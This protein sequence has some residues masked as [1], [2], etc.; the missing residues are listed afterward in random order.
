MNKKLY[1]AVGVGIFI[2]VAGFV[3]ITAVRPHAESQKMRVVTSFYPLYFFASE[4]GGDKAEVMNVTPAGAEPHDYEPTSQ[5][6]IAIQDSDLFVFNGVGFE[7]WVGRILQDTAL[8]GTIVEAADGLATLEGDEHEHEHEED[9]HVEAVQGEDDHIMDPHV[10]L[11]PVL[12]SRMADRIAQGFVAADPA[13]ASYY[14]A[15]AESLKARLSELDAQ[16]QTGLARCA[17][18]DFVTSHA[19]F[20]YLAAAYKINQ[21]P[22]SG[23]SPKEEPSVRQLATIATFAREH[24]VQHIFFEEL[25][26]PKLAQTVATEIGAQTLVLNPIEGLAAEDLKAGKNYLTEMSENLA[27]LRIALQC[28]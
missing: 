9:E 5:D 27:H 22:I 25:V 28:E 11:S 7:A 10:W 24:G 26:S 6:I 1:S 20:G 4:I 13:N 16:Y 23:L 3:W 21:V 14:T 17:K 12:A 8:Q 2:V 18:K 15:N 19:A